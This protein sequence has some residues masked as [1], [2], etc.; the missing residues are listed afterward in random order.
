[1]NSTTFAEAAAEMGLPK[2]LLYSISDVCS[3]LGIPPRTMYG[4]I[5]AERITVFVPNGRKHGMLIR[6]E[7]V[8]EWIKEGTHERSDGMAS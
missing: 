3:V 7:W 1:M 8:D 2:K 6:P 4:E 5:S